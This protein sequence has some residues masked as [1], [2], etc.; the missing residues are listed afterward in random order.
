M[1]TFSEVMTLVSL[2][3]EIISL[4]NYLKEKFGDNWPQFVKDLNVNLSAINQAKT[5][6]EIANA[7]KELQNLIARL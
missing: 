4:I 1:L 5:P 7:S 6:E 2:L 3:P